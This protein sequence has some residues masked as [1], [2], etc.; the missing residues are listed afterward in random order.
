M[1]LTVGEVKEQAASAMIRQV[2][3]R[4][5]I[6]VSGY[7]TAAISTTTVIEIDLLRI[8]TDI[9]NLMT[10]LARLINSFI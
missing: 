8:G 4:K 9:R 1:P 7:I 10:T 3:G 2:S 6:V 5:A